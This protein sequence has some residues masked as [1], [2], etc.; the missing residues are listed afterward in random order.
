VLFES[1][2]LFFDNEKCLEERNSKCEWSS[3]FKAR[4]S[5][6]CDEDISNDRKLENHFLMLAEIFVDK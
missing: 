5:N 1:N 2:W 3:K 4:Q 6:I